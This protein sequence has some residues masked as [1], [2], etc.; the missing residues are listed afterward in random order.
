MYRYACFVIDYRIIQRSKRGEVAAFILSMVCSIFITAAWSNWTGIENPQYFPLSKLNPR[1]LRWPPP[2]KA[3]AKFFYFL[4]DYHV[5]P[6]VILDCLQSAFFLKIRLVLISASV[7][8][9]HDV[10]LRLCYADALVYHGSRLSRS[11][12]WVSRA[13]T[14]QRKIRN[15]LAV[16][17]NTDLHIYI[18][19]LTLQKCEA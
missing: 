16:Y 7:I 13:V 2:L 19:R 1:P 17:C 11:G 5:A 8:A 12:A 6:S 9:N 10:M 15:L 3:A 14:L 18:L 4:K